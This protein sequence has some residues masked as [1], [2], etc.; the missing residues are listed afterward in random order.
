[1]GGGEG[2]Q[3]ALVSFLERLEFEIDGGFEE[4]RAERLELVVCNVL[5]LV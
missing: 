1:L 3:A 5:K 2:K 4:I